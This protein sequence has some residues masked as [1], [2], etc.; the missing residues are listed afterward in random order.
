MR[1]GAE[2]PRPADVARDAARELARQAR[3][4]GAFD[5]T[6]YFRGDQ[7]VRFHGVTSGTVRDLARTIDSLY[8]GAWGLAG[9]M[10]FANALIVSEYL[11]EK[12]LGIEL[13]AR[14]R[15]EFA[16]KQLAA[17]K[18]WLADNHA[19]NWA[20]TDTICGSLIGPLLVTYPKLAPKVA[21]WAG[22]RNMW[23]RRASAVALIRPVAR[24]EQ[25]DLAY[26]AAARLHADDRDLIQKAVG[27]MLREAGKV[28]PRRLERYLRDN[29]PSIPRT[30]V[31]YAIERFAERK[32]TVLLRDTKRPA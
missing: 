5:P 22:H 25:L 32:R 24:G 3:P 16:P 29:G 21:K 6:R 27:W 9:A 18:G 20:T 17:W 12:G 2:P 13:V 7:P 28:D 1:S 19:N 4:L 30:T 8:G 11:D 26:A 14:H 31:R 10:E 15:R 23:V